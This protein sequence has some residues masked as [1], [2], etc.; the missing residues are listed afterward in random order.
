[1]H[2]AS[3][4][5][6]TLAP[7]PMRQ[8]FDTIA[9]LFDSGRLQE[10]NAKLEAALVHYSD[11]VNFLHLGGLI[12]QN[13]GELELAETMLRTAQAL[14]PDQPDISHN[15]AVFFLAT[16]KAQEAVPIFEQ[17]THF[18]PKQAHVWVNYGHALR[19]MGKLTEALAAFARAEQCG[20]ASADIPLIK[21]ML[22]R[23]LALWQVEPLQ[24]AALTPNLAPVFLADPMQH[25]LCVQAGAAAIQPVAVYEAKAQRKASR[26]RIGYLSSDFHD[27]ATSHLIAELFALHDR[28]RFEVFVYSY[29]VEDKSA[30]RGRLQ[31][32]AEHWVECAGKPPAFIAERIFNDRIAILVDLKGYTRDAVPEVVAARPAPLTIQ[33]LGFPGSMGAN[34]IDYIIADKQLIPETLRPAYS[35]KIIHM[36]HSYQINDRQRPKPQLKP[37]KAYDLP[38][39]ALVLACFNQVY[40]ITPEVFAV[41]MRI[42]HDIP[43]AVLWLFATHAESIPHLQQE[44][45]KSGIA[46]ARLIFA[47]RLPQAEHISRY[48][49]GDVV[50][51]TWPYGGH[52]TIS[53]ALWAGV[54][55]VGLVGQS[56]A[57]RVS[58]SLLAAVGLPEFAAPSLAEY[59]TLL[60]ALLTDPKKRAIIRTYL[61]EKRESLPL[62]DTPAFVKSLEAGYVQAWETHLAKQPPHDIVL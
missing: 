30:V 49:Q 16:G 11:N 4:R 45:E 25:L 6:L 41:W 22:Q 3:N 36:P 7:N 18:A 10:A 15:L 1:M 21:A 44:A 8:T 34:F 26:L 42:L 35:E 33:W 5:T 51:D 56:F 31:K 28:A 57:A 19:Q 17:L 37:R 39:N 43:S 50:A 14:K 23:Q 54:P 47:R 2:N 12:K 59:E 60:R 53:D 38:E 58:Y 13:I 62:F 46:P 32:G 24:M 55:V 61:Q 40:K 29:G 9:K 20:G 48:L 52:T 27:H